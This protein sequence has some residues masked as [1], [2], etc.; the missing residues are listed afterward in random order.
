[1]YVAARREGLARTRQDHSAD[2]AV[3]I[4]ARGGGGEVLRIFRRAE[5]IAALR[6]VDREGHDRT[7]LFENQRITHS[8]RASLLCIFSGAPKRA[9]S[10][11]ENR[12]MPGGL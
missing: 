3:R 1:L 11:A 7:V 6:P 9:V 5:G 4:D 8:S 2:V 10:L 12:R